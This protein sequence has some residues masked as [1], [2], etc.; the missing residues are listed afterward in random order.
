MTR[1]AP[2][3]VLVVDDDEDDAFLT[4]ANLAASEGQRYAASRARS[5]AE[6]SA[7]VGSSAPDVVLLDFRLGPESGLDVLR[8]LRAEGFEG[9]VLMLTSAGDRRVDLAAIAAGADDYLDKVGLEPRLLERAI[10]HAL[11]HRAS[12]RVLREQNAKLAALS[13]EKN[14][15]LGMAA[16]DLRSPLGAIAGYARLLRD[17]LTELPTDDARAMLD[18]IVRS[19]EH[20]VGLVDDL[21]D[22]STIAAGTLVLRPTT[23][24][25]GPLVESVVEEMRPL[26]RRKRIQIDVETTGA[27]SVSIDRDRMVQVVSN[28]VGNAIK[29]SHP[30]GSVSVRVGPVARGNALV[31]EDR[32]VGIGADAQ[33]QL[34]LP[35]QRGR[36]TGTAGEK[37]VGLGLS[38]VRRIVEAHGGVI[39]V[40]SELGTGSTFRVV[41]PSMD[42]APSADPSTT[43]SRSR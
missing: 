8:R 17:E 37:S 41:I 15:F 21:L 9:A 34:F 38:I 28:L 33:R 25:L 5:G 43:T 1:P 19:S 7:Q 12:E 3:R 14:F 24:A 35:F 11:A 31:V 42:D 13:E 6:A 32:G 30:G 20:M 23:M 40:T 4:H 16:H 29:Y 22:L 39:S 26:A 2:I 18:T 10:R 27:P 36:A